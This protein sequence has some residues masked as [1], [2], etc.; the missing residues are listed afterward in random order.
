MK[1][2]KGALY[3]DKDPFIDI[4]S[5]CNKLDVIIFSDL[6]NKLDENFSRK[7]LLWF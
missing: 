3:D 1:I 4:L 5:L 2:Y 7:I 6:K